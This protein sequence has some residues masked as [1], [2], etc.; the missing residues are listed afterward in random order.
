M[1]GRSGNLFGMRARALSAVALLL[2][3]ATA[4]EAPPNGP[5]RVDPMW[6]ALT[7]A[8]VHVAPG[9]T[10]ENATVVLKG[11]RIAAVGT[12]APPEG[13]RI[14]DGKGLHV[15]AGLIDAYVPV[16][17]PPGE[18]R[19]W[20]PRITPWRLAREVD[21]AT[22]KELRGLGFTA[23]AV[24]PKGGILRGR[25]SLV[26]LAPRDEDLSVPRPTVYAEGV[27][28][29]TGLDTAEDPETPGARPREGYPTS[30]MGAIALLRQSFLDGLAP[31]EPLLFDT[32]DELEALRAAKIAREFGR[33]AAILGCGTEFRRLEAIAADGLPFVVPLRFPEP[34]DVSSV[35]AADAADLR[36]LM[37]WEQAPTNLRRLDA[38]GVSVAITTAKLSKRDKFFKRLAEAMRHGL[39][40]ERALAMLTATPAKLLH[41]DDRM[42]TVEAGKLANLVVTEG[43][44]FV[45]EPLIRDVWIEGRRY[46]VTPP[47]APSAG[48]WQVEGPPLPAPLTLSVTRK[49]QGGYEA[50]LLSGD[51]KAEVQ[52]LSIVGERIG[53]SFDGE[54]LGPKGRFTL[55][56]V[57]TADA[58]D[59]QGIGP[60]GE[61]F[62]WHA[63]RGVAPAPPPVPAPEP[64]DAPEKYGTRSA[65]TRSTGFPR[66]RNG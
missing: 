19:H 35:G 23:A 34:P 41:A 29:S 22:A 12:D 30:Q 53:F 2:S 7:G 51:K 39:A 28:Q 65:P 45:A 15:Y 8:T 61:R 1:A 21:D 27:W 33:T 14:W 59:G 64:A 24:A 56:A 62:H 5:R 55:S 6:H 66:S 50:T 37:T 9:Q 10:L 54:P 3:L 42:G 58:L 32:G 60:A 46:E 31:L 18:P 44:L 16:D 26:S 38:A 52:H 4:Q 20:N 17:V 47:R 48:A 57:A 49:P 13:A 63:A 43:P 11:D 40:E 36:D 25:A